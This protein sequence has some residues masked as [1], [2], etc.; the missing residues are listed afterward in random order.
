L[1]RSLIFSYF[2]FKIRIYFAT[3]AICAKVS[4]KT[5]VLNVY[6][7]YF[8]LKGAAKKKQAML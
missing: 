5:N 6:I 3:I 8:A 4:Q 2:K 1:P 7:W